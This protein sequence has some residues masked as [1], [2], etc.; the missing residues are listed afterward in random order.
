M[1]FNKNFDL[2]NSDYQSKTIS[3]T[4]YTV[5]SDMIIEPVDAAFFKKH[6]RIDFETDD[7]LIP[8]YIKAARIFLENYTMKSFG[9]KVISFT[10]SEIPDKYKLMFGPVKDIITTGFSNVGDLLSPGGSDIDIQFSTEGIV[11]DT[12]KIA[13][14]RYAAGLY[15]N[16]ENIIDSKLSAIA[17]M[18]QSK[19]M[20]QSYR[21]IILF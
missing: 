19:V 11:D 4:N 17:L 10:A 15:M 9:I 5:V 18:D 8:Y 21:N 13:I 6:A 1:D 7:D 2:L 16:R 14:C 3:G 12:I 20:L